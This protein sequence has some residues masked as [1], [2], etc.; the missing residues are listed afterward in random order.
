[1][2]IRPDLLN[3]LL[4]ELVQSQSRPGCPVKKKKSR[5]TNPTL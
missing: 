2:A 3:V 1:M 4:L 5:M